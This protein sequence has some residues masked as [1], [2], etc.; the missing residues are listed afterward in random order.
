MSN[1][2]VNQFRIGFVTANVWENSSGD[3]TFYNVTL[4]R[5]YK[6][7]GEYKQTDSLSQGD[8]LNCAKVLERAE[9][10]IAEQ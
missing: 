1:A 10:W 4:T 2:P 7:G 6:D 3:R 9:A 8:L 5:T